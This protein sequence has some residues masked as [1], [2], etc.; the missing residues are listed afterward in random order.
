MGKALRILIVD[1]EAELGL[2]MGS[3][4][5]DEGYDADCITDPMEAEERVEK[6]GYSLVISDIRMPG[7]G[8]M[9]LL[10]RLKFRFPDLAVIMLTGY[11]SIEN[12]VAA[13]KLG[14]ENFLKKPL[15][16]EE[17]IREVS[18]IHARFCNRLH[19]PD[20][21]TEESMREPGHENIIYSCEAM[22]TVVDQLLAVADTDAPVLIGG[23][24][25]TGK[26]LAAELL[27]RNSARKDGPFV[28]INCAALS[29]SLLS[30]ELFGSEEGAY[31]GSVGRSIGKFEAASGGTIFLD[32]IGD[33]AQNT[34]AKILRVLQ[35][36]ELYRVGGNELIRVDIRVIAATNKDL[37]SLMR[38]GL[39]REDL[40]YRLSV[41]SCSLPPLRE[42]REDIPLLI[43]SFL[44]E[45]NRSYRRRVSGF[46]QEALSMLLRHAW[47]GNIRELKNCVERCCLLTR[48][49][50]VPARDLPRQYTTVL[51]NA[52][53]GKAA[54]DSLDEMQR[55]R[56][57]DALDRS[58]G[59]RKDAAR[60][61]NIDRRTL[62]NRMKRLG[63]K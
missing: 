21:P 13:M 56:I 2:T 24:S 30:A 54:Y 1:D 18:P 20:S 7:L 61:L 63:I 12:A 11:P 41:F 46:T 16:P 48:E 45:F 34:Q 5:R 57:M 53:V 9:T 28:R 35:N 60:M 4:L 39:F 26:E 50:E 15:H 22:R 31:T 37:T 38:E 42:R 29:E 47:P 62:Y 32:E 17:L 55:G 59:V 23:E 44:K 8:G 49:G 27:H 14:A 58:G 51:Q 3:I 52:P 6:G 33:M 10:E 43:E 25:G 19:S 40:Y 36:K